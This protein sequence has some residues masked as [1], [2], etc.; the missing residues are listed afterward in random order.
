MPIQVFE[1]AKRAKIRVEKPSGRVIVWRNAAG[2]GGGG[3]E[4]GREGGGSRGG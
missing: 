4:G 2:R 3:R 1:T